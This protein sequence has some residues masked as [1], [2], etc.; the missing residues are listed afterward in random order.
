M[1]KIKIGIHSSLDSK[2]LEESYSTR[3]K[4]T[5]IRAKKRKTID[6]AIL[7][8]CKT[9]KLNCTQIYTH[10]PRTYKMT[11]INV[12]KV[13]KVLSDYNIHLIVHATHAFNNRIWSI[14]K[15]TTEEEKYK[16]ALIYLAEQIKTCNL[17]NSD[18]VVHLPRS[19]FKSTK[20][21]IKL[22]MKYFSKISGK[23][24]FENVPTKDKK[25]M[26]SIIAL[27]KL[28]TWLQT[29]PLKDK[30]GY[31]IDTAHMWSSSYDMKSKTIIDFF[32]SFKNPNII[33][34]IHLNGSTKKTFNSNRDVH[35]I[36]ASNLDD[37]FNFKNLETL[38]GIIKKL[39]IPI[40]CEINRGGES[41]SRQSLKLCKTLYLKI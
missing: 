10:V 14:T 29:T 16:V 39:E 32:N 3:N 15:D 11:K 18:L 12:K 40:I 30:W 31:C 2:V 33:R 41:L 22:L 4:T 9:L 38:L 27:N 21:V 24:L 25:G 7:D 23:I 35:I 6:Q 34:L 8:D 17:L 36:A 28:Y 20:K 1:N 19:E 5:L 13:N 37:I 26:S